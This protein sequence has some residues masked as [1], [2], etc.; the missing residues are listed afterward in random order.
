VFL[1]V[2]VEDASEFEDVL[3]VKGVEVGEHKVL[4]ALS[5]VVPNAIAALLLHLRDTTGK[6]PH[7]YFGWTEGNPIVY[8]FRFQLLGE[9]DTA[10]VTHEVLR[11]AEPD[12]TRRP[13]VHVGGR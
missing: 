7:C 8:L 2:D 10:P 12:G 3:E 1:E 9:G 5:S 11:E 6:T 13:A 4:R